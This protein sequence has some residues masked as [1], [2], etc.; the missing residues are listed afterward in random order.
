MIIMMW[1]FYILVL[2]HCC[3]SSPFR[4]S[5]DLIINQSYVDAYRLLC[6]SI[7][8]TILPNY[9]AI[10]NYVAN[11]KHL[12]SMHFCIS[13]LYIF[14]NFCCKNSL[15]PVKQPAT[16]AFSSFAHRYNYFAKPRYI[17]N[18]KTT[19]KNKGKNIKYVELIN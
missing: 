18:Y 8:I 11:K 17:K 14:I 4:I 12:F 5:F 3:R 19:D 16:V 1:K 13:H 15:E 6:N 9:Y 10:N 2:F 7:Q